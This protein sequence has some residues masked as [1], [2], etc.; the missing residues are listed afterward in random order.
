MMLYQRC[1]KTY[2]SLKKNSKSAKKRLSTPKKAILFIEHE[3]QSNAS[4][5]ARKTPR[6]GLIKVNRYFSLLGKANVQTSLVN[7]KLPQRRVLSAQKSMFFPNTL[8]F[9]M[10][11]LKRL[12]PF[13]RKM[14]LLGKMIGPL[15][16]LCCHDDD[17]ILHIDERHEK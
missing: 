7:E 12:S 14:W 1:F 8:W 11:F 17:Q 9:L 13:F 3:W 16:G 2:F 15:P 5:K 6:K 10:I 4:Q